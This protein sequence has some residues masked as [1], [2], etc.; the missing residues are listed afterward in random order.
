MK[1][2]AALFCLAIRMLCLSCHNNAR[3]L[4]NSS[5]AHLGVGLCCVEVGMVGV[6]VVDVVLLIG[7]G[8]RV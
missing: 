1:A 6:R 2:D 3:L 4:R 5:R 7:K 8:V